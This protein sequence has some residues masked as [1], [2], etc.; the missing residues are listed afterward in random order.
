MNIPG[1]FRLARFSNGQWSLESAKE[2]YVAI[3]H[4][5]TRDEKENGA[6]TNPESIGYKLLTSGHG[7]ITRTEKTFWMDTVCIMQG[8]EEDKAMQIPMMHKI[9]SRAKAVIVLLSSTNGFDLRECVRLMKANNRVLR[10]AERDVYNERMTANDISNFNDLMLI[11]DRVTAD[12]WFE[13][14]WTLQEV[15]VARD[16]LWCSVDGF[17]ACFNMMDF[18]SAAEV[19]NMANWEA[20]SA[21]ANGNLIRLAA[22]MAAVARNMVDESR[23]IE[24]MPNRVCWEPEDAVY[25]IMG[26]C[27][28]YVK[29]EYNIGG[30]DVAWWRLQMQGLIHG[31]LI[32]TAFLYPA[33]PLTDKYYRM[34]FKSCAKA[35]ANTPINA[36]PHIDVDNEENIVVACNQVYRCIVESEMLDVMEDV[37]ENLVN[38][39]QWITAN[40]QQGNCTERLCLALVANLMNNRDKKLLSEV[41]I[42]SVSDDISDVNYQWTCISEEELDAC[43]KFTSTITVTASGSACCRCYLGYIPDAQTD[44]ALYLYD[45]EVG[46]ELLLVDVGTQDPYTNRILTVVEPNRGRRLGMSGSVGN[47]RG[48]KRPDKDKITLM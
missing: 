44:V 5:W 40:M 42:R 45:V 23:V 20:N 13:R 18:I 1:T 26:L 22:G 30:E 29:P 43:G 41:L 24:L 11:L 21:H 28:V 2:E 35:S 7:H 9:Y 31:Q 3:S 37:E 25:S 32:R 16:V 10:D 15:A 46:T 47:I 38:R 14:C 27:N 39:C 36:F 17:R 48:G 6:D 4:V 19:Y 33:S 12:S 34:P 8:N